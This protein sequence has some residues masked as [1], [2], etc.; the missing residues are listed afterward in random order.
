MMLNRFSG[1]LKSAICPCICAIGLFLPN[2]HAQTVS[3]CETKKFVFIPVDD[4]LSVPVLVNANPTSPPD[5]ARVAA[6]HIFNA[7]GNALV[8]RLPGDTLQSLAQ[9]AYGNPCMWWVIAEANNAM[10]DNELLTLSRVIIPN[11]ENS[12]SNPYV[13]QAHDD[14]VSIHYFNKITG[15]SWQEYYIP[16]ASQLDPPEYEDNPSWLNGLA[17]VNGNDRWNANSFYISRSYPNPVVSGAELVAISS[18]LPETTRIDLPIDPN[19]IAQLPVFTGVDAP[20]PPISAAPGSDPNIAAN[21]LRKY[22][23]KEVLEVVRIKGIRIITVRRSIIEVI[24]S[25]RDQPIPSWGPGKTWNDVPGGYDPV[26]KLIVIATESANHGSVSLADH[27]FAHAYNDAM[28]KL[29]DK[30]E[31]DAVFNGDWEALRRADRTNVG[32]YSKPDFN[33]G[34]V[35]PTFRRARS[36][37]FAEGMSNYFNGNARW[38]SDKPNL[39]RYFQSYSRPQPVRQ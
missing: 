15:I 20:P 7:Q 29:S 31:F 35:V 24:P 5:P 22:P 30:P 27:E 1:N 32:Y 12:S 38:F 34:E 10:S 37:A 2:A 14:G 21:M 4:D 11:I 9:A 17:F 6:M 8:D 36:E 19:V 13:I 33:T 39:L 3:S 28:G 25:L 23:D 18:A 16:V 26:R